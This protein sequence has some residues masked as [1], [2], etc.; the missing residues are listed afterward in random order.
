MT[1]IGKLGRSSFLTQTA[2]SRVIKEV[3]A[4][5]VPTADSRQSIK[6]GRD[7]E[8]DIKTPYG[9]VL[10]FEELDLIPEK[11]KPS[12]YKFPFVNPLAYMYYVLGSCA[13]FAT[14]FKGVCNN[15]SLRFTTLGG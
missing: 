13:A 4:R 11:G 6:R 12:T 15:R 5:G 9:Q 7:K 8:I 2:L 1:D 14:F 3:K 10:I